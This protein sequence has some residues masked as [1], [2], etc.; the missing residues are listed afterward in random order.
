MLKKEQKIRILCEQKIRV[1][2][3]FNLLKNFYS[4]T[5]SNK[6]F[7]S[8]QEF[9]YPLKFF[10]WSK[11]KFKTI[12]KTLLNLK[13]S[14]AYLLK[15]HQQLFRLFLDYCY[16]KFF[17][18]GKPERQK[19]KQ[20]EF[21]KNF[22]NVT[23][24]NLKVQNFNLETFILNFKKLFFVK[25]KNQQ[26][27]KNFQSFSVIEKYKQTNFLQEKNFREKRDEISK[28][29]NKKS[30]N[31]NFVKQCDNNVHYY[32]LI[33][34]QQLDIFN[35][36]SFDKRSRDYISLIIQNKSWRFES[37]YKV[38]FLSILNFFR[39]QDRNVELKLSLQKI[40]FNSNFAKKTTKF[41][42]CFFK[43]MLKRITLFLKSKF[44]TVSTKLN[45]F[46]DVNDNGHPSLFYENFQNSKKK[47]FFEV[48]FP[49]FKFFDSLTILPLEIKRLN[50]KRPIFQ[51]NFSEFFEKKVLSN[52]GFALLKKYEF[53]SLI[54]RKFYLTPT[55]DIFFQNKSLNYFT[56]DLNF[57]KCKCF[58]T[59]I[60]TPKNKTKLKFRF[61]YVN[62]LQNFSSISLICKQSKKTNQFLI[63]F[64][65]IFEKSL[66]Q[67][68]NLENLVQIDLSKILFSTILYS[69]KNLSKINIFLNQLNQKKNEDIS[70][71][72][73]IFSRVP[74]DPT[75]L[76]LTIY[77]D[78][79]YEIDY[80]SFKLKN[81]LLNLKKVVKLNSAQKQEILIKRL[82][83][84]TY[85]WCYYQINFPIN[86][87][88]FY[89][90][91][92]QLYNF[93]WKWACRRHNNKSKYWI[94][95]K[96]FYKLNNKIWLFGNVIQN[97]EILSSS[98]LSINKLIYLPFH[99]EII[100]KLK[101]T[102]PNRNVVKV[103]F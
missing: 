73:K 81:Y 72:Q 94:Q 93:L 51:T 45:N 55:E 20:N 65:Q 56:D 2:Q 9:Q 49:E 83:A 96:Y 100:I 53:Y 80:N 86:F 62:F 39:F 19:Q 64:T 12:I 34:Q 11:Q 61:I 84:K 70:K 101:G 85:T 17:E 28:F 3:N 102:A 37:I 14:Y 89:L 91:D 58:K 4:Q 52:F 16:I 31:E 1:I 87:K 76:I 59:F 82:S 47:V 97:S 75:N 90:C 40:K 22:E 54:N 6:V 13:V 18:I 5:I 48:L 21:F 103:N 24:L 77:S 74:I 15:K 57:C 23:S 42:I 41:R 50:F 25:R 10:F 98:T 32:L 46:T 27:F 38:V 71:N 7:L 66:I 36:N 67:K 33:L 26:F 35:T 88:S 69:T 99:L 60:R 30:N 78:Y 92:R 63:D 43:I 44:L 29:Q 8:F 95:S 79:T 68:L